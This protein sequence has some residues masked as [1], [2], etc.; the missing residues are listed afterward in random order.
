MPDAVRLTDP[1]AC[2]T[3]PRAGV[4]KKGRLMEIFRLRP[5]HIQGFA[6]ASVEAY[7]DR[8]VTHVREQLSQ[9]VTDLPPARIRERARLAIPRAKAHG[10]V[11]EY[12]ALC[13][14]DATFLLGEAFDKD[15]V[16]RAAQAILADRTRTAV[17]R[18]DQLLAE[19]CRRWGEKPCHLNRTSG[20]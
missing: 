14:I 2:A 6:E 12:E 1:H 19:A 11:S 17:E 3:A 13:F 8:V 18:A 20:S 4:I 7:L 16:E 5:G 9:A 15:P 10:L